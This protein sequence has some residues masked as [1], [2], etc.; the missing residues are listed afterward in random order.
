MELVPFWRFLGLIFG[1][2]ATSFANFNLYLNQ[3]ETKRLLGI[4]SEV[5]YVR[6]GIVNDYA[7]SFN[8]PVPTD[9]VDIYFNWQN[10]RRSMSDKSSELMMYSLSFALS[11]NRAMFQPEPNIPA[12]GSV[13][14]DMS[15]F[16]VTLPCSG[17]LDTEVDIKI[18]L[19]VSIFSAL[20]VT[21][22]ELRRRKTCRLGKPGPA[23]SEPAASSH[24]FYIGIG[25]A[26]GAIIVIAL[27]VFIYYVQ[28][29]KSTNEHFGDD[30]D[31]TVSLSRDPVYLKNDHNASR[32]TISGFQSLSKRGCAA[33]CFME[34]KPE[35]VRSNL[36]PIAVD[37]SRVSLAEILMEGTLGR[38]Y[39]GTMAVQSTTDEV[40]QVFVKT[41]TDEA[42]SDQIEVMLR[43]GSFTLG[44]KHDNINSI[45]ASCIDEDQHPMLIYTFM[46]EGNLKKFLQRCKISDVGFKQVLNT[47]QLVYIAIQVTKAIHYLHRKRIIHG[48]I[49]TRNCVVDSRLNV[50]VTDNA[51]SRDLFPNEYHCLGDN[52]NR[53]VKWI[54][55]EALED[56]RFSTAS[57]MWSFGV[58]LWELMTLGQIPYANIDAFEMS[59]Y[60]KA[61]YRVTQPVNCPNEL[62]AIMACC[63][64]FSPDERPKFTQLQL[65]LQDFYTALGQFV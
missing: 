59:T 11:N 45:I 65:C 1:L 30:V 57:D 9:I 50:Q 8:L 13:P 6:A 21:T 10:L 15:V 26:C 32:S 49:A 14:T 38:I 25:C 55:L 44:L 17:E 58:L 24:V 62:F 40:Q 36:K 35:N 46:N 54:A 43:E 33:S 28:T 12:H 41:I 18:F 27:C 47:Q 52:E 3:T 4:E 19:N 23:S 63:W 5:F 61:G 48:D 31:S 29:K 53:P 56:R 39:I 16:K 60:L 2:S 51:L 22:L 20:N 37:R 64:S 7:L 34:L 42:R